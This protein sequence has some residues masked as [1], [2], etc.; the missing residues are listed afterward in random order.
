MPVQNSKEHPLLLNFSDSGWKGIHQG[1]TRFTIPEDHLWECINAVPLNPGELAVIPGSTQVEQIDTTFGQISWMKPFQIGQTLYVGVMQQTAF[2]LFNVN[3]MQWVSNGHLG[4]V[5]AGQLDAA[6]WRNDKIVIATPA[7]VM[8]WDPTNGYVTVDTTITGNR[9][10]V[11]Q[12]RV[13][14]FDTGSRTVK[15]SDV[16]NISF[17]TGTAGAFE[18]NDSSF[19]GNPQGAATYFG[20]L[21]FWTP[22]ALGSISNLRLV[23]VGN[24]Q[25]AVFDVSSMETEIGTNQQLGVYA[26]GATLFMVSKAGIFT[27]QGSVPIKISDK[28]DD[29]WFRNF[30]S[31]RMVTIAFSSVWG[32]FCWLFCLPILNPSNA[33]RIIG[34]TQ[35]G[36]WFSLSPLSVNTFEDNYPVAIVSLYLGGDVITI[37]ADP[38]GRIWRLFANTSASV[39][40][41]FQT[42]LY[43]FGSP[44]VRKRVQKVGIALGSINNQP[45]TGLNVCV[46]DETGSYCTPVNFLTGLQFG[47]DNGPTGEITGLFTWQNSSNQNLTV[48]V[49]PGPYNWF[50]TSLQ[51]GK[52]PPTS[53]TRFG[54]HVGLDVSGN[55]QPY[56][57][58][59]LAMQVEPVTEWY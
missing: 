42:K 13:W 2:K 4:S 15:F 25:Q 37:A 55:S 43:D 52:T 24:A 47:Y 8:T 22:N 32:Q 21:I 30:D 10:A 28:L 12:D 18:I 40:H 54:R 19:L 34:L 5:N 45:I 11:W 26:A 51:Q 41:L 1:A 33:W 20:S 53:I 36:L 44:I 16:G 39:P 46:V 27:V 7:G 17:S 29:W 59:E 23:T 50:A 49:A 9:V 6:E 57:L 31:S 3:A 56:V 14:V 48:G 58:L 38:S 35:N